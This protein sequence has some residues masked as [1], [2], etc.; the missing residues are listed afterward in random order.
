MGTEGLLL[1]LAYAA[2]AGSP[3]F[4]EERTGLIDADQR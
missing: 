2:G 4:S 1:Y 3:V